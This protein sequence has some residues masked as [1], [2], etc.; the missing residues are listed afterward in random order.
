MKN[1][2][3]F[4]FRTKENDPLVI[5]RSESPNNLGYSFD[6]QRVSGKFFRV[7]PMTINDINALCMLDHRVDKFAPSEGHGVIVSQ[8]ALEN[9][10]IEL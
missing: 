8:Q 7:I 2:H 5:K 10:G 6:E 9:F 3:L 1:K 4:K